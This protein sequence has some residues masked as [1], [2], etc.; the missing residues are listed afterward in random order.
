MR[1]NRSPGTCGHV[2]LVAPGSVTHSHDASQRY[3]EL[4]LGAVTGTSVE[5]LAPPDAH[6]A[7]P[8]WYMLF[9]VSKAGVPSVAEWIELR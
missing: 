3:V 4:A 5:I 2:A 9:L 8:G 6:H 7:P 1:Q